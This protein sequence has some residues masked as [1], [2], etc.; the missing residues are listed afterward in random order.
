V[1]Q[2]FNTETYEANRAFCQKRIPKG[3]AYGSPI[4]LSNAIPVNAPVMVIEMNIETNRI[5]GIGLITNMPHKCKYRIY[6]D[7]IEKHAEYNRYA[8]V[9]K[10]RIDRA[11]MTEH[12]NRIIRAFEIMCF[13]GKDHIKRGRGLLCFP[14]KKLWYAKD[15]IDLVQFIQNMFRHRINKNSV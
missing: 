13:Y 4:L 5:M 1:T 6:D 3:C 15:V 8:Y 12:E 9:G 10:Y 2:R 11:E 7:S 14:L